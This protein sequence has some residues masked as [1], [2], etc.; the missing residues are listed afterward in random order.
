MKMGTELM[1][2]PLLVK[3]FNGG[4]DRGMM[5]AIDGKEITKDQA[6][7]LFN[8]LNRF[9]N[10]NPPIHN[11]PWTP[12]ETVSTAVFSSDRLYRY[13]LIRIWDRSRDVV[14]FVGLNPSTADETEDDPTIRRCVN[15]AKDWGY[16][17]LVMLNLF[18]YRATMP[19]EM[20]CQDDPIG[21]ENDIWTLVFTH[22]ADKIILSW[23][24]SG[25][26]KGRDKAVIDFL[27]KDKLFT[28]GL[29]KD[30]YPKHPLYLK[31]DTQLIE[32]GSDE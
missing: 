9:L 27:P 7:D 11:Y 25:E 17:G 20:M 18:G 13:A 32:W 29:T 19:A 1:R 23:G 24:T 31:K 26:Y 16:G 10:P 2:E 5:L 28:L 4:K 30:G 22:W 15:F 8:I 14:A 21:F 3:R 12:A 6:R